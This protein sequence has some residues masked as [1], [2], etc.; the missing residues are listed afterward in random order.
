MLHRNSAPQEI[1]SLAHRRCYHSVCK[2]VAPPLFPLI[3]HRL[4]RIPSNRCRASLPHPTS[5]L[6]S[7]AKTGFHALSSFYPSRRVSSR[8]PAFKSCRVFR[9][10]CPSL[11]IHLPLLSSFLSRPHLHLYLF[12]LSVHPGSSSSS[13]L[14]VF[15]RSSS[16]HRYFFLFSSFFF[17]AALLTLP[18]HR[19]GPFQFPPCRAR[20]YPSIYLSSPFFF[21]RFRGYSVNDH[22]G[23]LKIT[24]PGLRSKR[25]PVRGLRDGNSQGKGGD[26]SISRTNQ[27]IK[28]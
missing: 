4:I 7:N 25:R 18:S 16:F 22:R 14:L 20:I 9:H 15:H 21:T 27:N 17:I 19:R 13:S 11:A 5:D 1:Q 2:I 23:N 6:D 24:R 28:I 10:D 26:I 3:H 12:L 8:R